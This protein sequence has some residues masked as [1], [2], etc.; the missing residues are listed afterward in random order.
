MNLRLS[1]NIDDIF[2]EESGKIIS[3]SHPLSQYKVLKSFEE[4]GSAC[5]NTGWS[6]I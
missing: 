3:S 2:V 4:S 1:Q 6:P 5:S